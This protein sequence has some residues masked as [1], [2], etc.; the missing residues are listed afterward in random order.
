MFGSVVDG[1]KLGSLSVLSNHF[2][3]DSSSDD[4]VSY[5]KDSDLDRFEGDPTS[6]VDFDC[7]TRFAVSG[8]VVDNSLRF[9]PVKS[10]WDLVVRWLIWAHN[11]W[12]LKEK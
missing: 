11:N 2:N 5:P 7:L 6:E 3:G 8:G 10:F 4:S 12:I 1:T 9:W